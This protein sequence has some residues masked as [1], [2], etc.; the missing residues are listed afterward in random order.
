M[1][2]KWPMSMCHLNKCIIVVL[3]GPFV[4]HRYIR[5]SGQLIDGN[6]YV[7]CFNCDIGCGCDPNTGQI[8]AFLQ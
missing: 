5:K 2:L 6:A 8:Q 1:A 4:Q 3:V 7:I